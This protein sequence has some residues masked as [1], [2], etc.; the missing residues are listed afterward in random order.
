[1]SKTNITNELSANAW[2]T[3]LA[4][5]DA[6]TVFESLEQAESQIEKDIR[7]KGQKFIVKGNNG[8]QPKEYWFLEDY[9]EAGG[10]ITYH[11]ALEDDWSRENDIIGKDRDWLQENGFGGN[12]ASGGKI[13]LQYGNIAW[14]QSNNATYWETRREIPEIIPEPVPYLPEVLEE[15]L[16]ALEKIS[17]HITQKWDDADDD[18]DPHNLKGFKTFVESAIASGS[19]PPKFVAHNLTERKIA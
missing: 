18:S 8:E 4:P 12:Q 1:M 5:Y 3:D 19:K 7:Y 2:L 6:K 14:L 9:R 17:G 13:A 10:S 16:K 15:D 11:W